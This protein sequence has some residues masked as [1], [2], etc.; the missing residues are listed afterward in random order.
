MPDF[1]FNFELADVIL[2]SL[3]CFESGSLG[4]GDVDGLAGAGVLTGASSL[5]ANFERTEANELNLIALLQSVF[6]FVQNSGDNNAGFLLC[7][8]AGD[9]R[10]RC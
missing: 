2:E 8:L 10:P 5:S 7:Q 9:L 3:T 1:I 6:D 4:S